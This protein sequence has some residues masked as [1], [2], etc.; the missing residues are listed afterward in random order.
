MSHQWATADFAPFATA[1]NAACG[2][3]HARR[4]SFQTRRSD[5]ARRLKRDGVANPHVGFRPD[6]F[7]SAIRTSTAGG[8]PPRLP[9]REVVRFNA[10]R[11]G[12]AGDRARKHHA[13]HRHSSSVPLP[14]HPGTTLRTQKFSMCQRTASQLIRIVGICVARRKRGRNGA[15]GYRPAEFFL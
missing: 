1:K 9:Q 6:V 3:G 10:R 11:D 5:R 8:K 2:C 7:A 12:V 14:G 13:P 15:A 4:L